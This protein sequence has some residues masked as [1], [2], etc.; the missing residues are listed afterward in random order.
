MRSDLLKAIAAA[1]DITN[2][3]VLTYNLDF[4]F[5]QTV[6][7]AAL[8]KC[9]HPTITVFVDAQCAAESFAHQAPV[10]D[11]LGVRYRVVPV[12]MSPGF[13]FHPKAVLL[14]GEK[15]ATLFV[16]S[17]NLTFGGWRENA[18]VWTRFDA[19]A[20]GSAA[21]VEFRRYVENVIERVPL[22]DAIV[23]EL[24]EAFDS[25][26]RRWLADDRPS[27]S[28]NL[29]GRVGS[30]QSL[31]QSMRAAQGPGAVDELVIC[32]PYFDSEGAALR[33]LIQGTEAAHATVL[34]QPAGTTLTREAFGAAAGKA[35]LRHASFEH[36][37]VGGE[38]RAAFIHAKFY[39]LRQGEQVLVFAGSANCSRA[40]LTASGPAGNAELMA[41]RR[42]A[43]PDFGDSFVGELVKLPDAVPLLE[44]VP[45]G[46]H[47]VNDTAL[48]VLA[49]R[50]DAGGLLLGF[51]PPR[52]D[53]RTCEIDG[54][55]VRFSLS[56]PGVLSVVCAFE[57]RSVRLEAV[58]DES[59]VWSAP[60]WIDHERHLRASARG[61]SLA[62]SIRARV[63]PGSWNASAWADVM[64]V[65]C[66]HLSYMPTRE[67]A[68]TASSPED[69][70][71]AGEGTFTFADVF[72]NSY[73][74]PELNELSQLTVKLEGGSE[75][76]LQQLLLRWFGIGDPAGAAT[77]VATD[78]SDE[79]DGDDAVDRPE[80]LPAKRVAPAPPTDADKH[81]IQKVLEQIEQAMTK[82]SFLA[83]RRPD[84]LAADLK[85]AAVLLRTGL[86][87]G[88]FNSASFFQ[89]THRIWSALFF[90]GSPDA[91]R[92]WLEY[93]LRH[94]E[95]AAG[96]IAALRS[97]E[98]AAALLGWAFAVAPSEATTQSARFHLAVALA[99]ARLHWLWDAGDDVAVAKELKVLL[100][101]T[102]IVG[103][104]ASD[105]R[106][107][108]ERMLKRGHALLRLEEAANAITLPTLRSR[109]RAAE[110]R[111]GDLLWQGA[112]GFCVV[113]RPTP[114]TEGQ[115]APVLRLQNRAEESHIAAP[116]TIPIESLLLEEV[117][118]P[119]SSFDAEPRR[120][121]KE[122]LGE[123]RDSLVATATVSASGMPR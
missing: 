68:R 3:I 116:F 13:R 63:Q 90:T 95:D 73:E 69:K 102:G 70:P 25:T 118:P 9:G 67:G 19:V 75:R 80:V 94:A 115:K 16:G 86:R 44:Q 47:G 32:S 88:W 11:G 5:L 99:V 79:L 52:A 119:S 35:T 74:A 15:D 53:V 96:F 85:I 24:S 45:D 34:C 57:P 111:T 22:S 121:L 117:V 7:L 113:T 17:G 29:L 20:D 39:G 1:K 42:M 21:F 8:R 50:L 78:V 61:R 122:F 54:A 97:P 40:A 92:G 87:E 108:W 23:D 109:I 114:R 14:S 12:A 31:L 65:F 81:R 18:E 4:V 76:S 38:K 6:A 84:Q 10:L 105:V 33:D 100:A 66:K 62:D 71:G 91:N 83:E 72:S 103:V 60:T 101:H 46:D 110:L 28:Q 112:A 120:V 49:A 58:V 89:T 82:E 77:E 56:E 43:A 27:T 37:S 41:V 26:T 30:G 106:A 51:T 93:R 59:L 107:A 36:V 48:R 64:D 104:T 55:A 123:L 98:L 2:A